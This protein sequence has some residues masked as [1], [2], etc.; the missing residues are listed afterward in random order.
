MIVTMISPPRLP[1][2]GWDIANV[3]RISGGL[4]PSRRVVRDDD[5]MLEKKSTTVLV[6]LSRID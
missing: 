5:D 2:L 1:D 3:R 6:S 4:G